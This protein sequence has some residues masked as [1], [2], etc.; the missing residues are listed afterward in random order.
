MGM[1]CA[2]TDLV[3]HWSPWRP[4]QP[5][6]V[7]QMYISACA[8]GRH[9]PLRLHAQ[10]P[11]VQTPKKLLQTASFVL[12]CETN[13]THL[14]KH[15]ESMWAWMILPRTCVFFRMMVTGRMPAHGRSPTY[16]GRNSTTAE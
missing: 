10:H 6:F 3:C 1:Q 14:L 16:L 5:R 12:C 2:R 13:S 15:Q 4:R 11:S 7:L 8:I 9:C